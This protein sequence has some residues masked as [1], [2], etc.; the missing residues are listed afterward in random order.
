MPLDNVRYRF[1]LLKHGKKQRL[2]F[3]GNQVVEAVTFDAKGKK[4][5]ATHTP[6]EF[7]AEKKRTPLRM[8]GHG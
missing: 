4:T 2:A 3:R 8:R 6:G 1:R 5:E 7:A